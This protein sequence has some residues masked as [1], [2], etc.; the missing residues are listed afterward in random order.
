VDASP[1]HAAP[2]PRPFF[3][4][5]FRKIKRKEKSQEHGAAI[6]GIM[7]RS[8]KRM[9][10]VVNI[11]GERSLGGVKRFVVTC[12]DRYICTSDPRQIDID[13]DREAFTHFQVTSASSFLMNGI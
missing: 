3:F 2:H 8:G 13:I 7:E 9:S 11:M 10:K 5:F 12:I 1:P 4:S 6:S